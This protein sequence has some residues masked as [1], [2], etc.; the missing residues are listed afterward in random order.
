MTMKLEV[1]GVP[2][3]NFTAASCEVR[4]DTLSSSFSF[5]A[6]ATAGAALPFKGGESCKVLVEDKTVLTGNIEVVDVSYDAT[7]H[8]IFIQGRDKTGDLLDSTLDAISDIRA[9]ISLKELIEKVLE[10]IGLKIDVIDNVNPPKF[11]EVEDIASP[12]SGDN[13]FAF[14]EKY[15]RKRQVLLTSDADGNI[16][17]DKNSGQ[18]AQGGIQNILGASDNNV[19]SG[20]FIF[21]TTGRYRVYRFSSQLNPVSL[22]SAGVTDLASIVSQR[23]GVSDSEIRLGRQLIL[24]SETPFS[25]EQCK[26]RSQWQADIQ[27]G[28][29]LTYAVTL[30]GYR[31]DLKNPNSDIWRTNRLYQ[32]TDDFLGKQQR[33]LSNSVTYS[34]SLDGGQ[35]TSIGFVDENTYTLDLI[36]PST[37]DIASNII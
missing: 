20:N 14:L 30:D 12:E 18:I 15:S 9:G 37:S 25:D 21:D 28:R 31:V 3:E 1:N 4:L 22:F 35:Q 17:I 34:L 2:Y 32:I 11:T 27:R 8:N 29:G 33:M 24:V 5:E 26:K 23:G 7:N 10:Q 13:A 19:R 16:V 6:V 36:T